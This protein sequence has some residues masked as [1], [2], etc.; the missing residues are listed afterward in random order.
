M[1]SEASLIE[2]YDILFFTLK[3]QRASWQV[4]ISAMAGGQ[5]NILK[6]VGL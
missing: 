1:T 4:E 5:L 3:S 2:V 6:P